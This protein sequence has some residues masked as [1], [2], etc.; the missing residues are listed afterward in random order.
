MLADALTRLASARPGG[1]EPA[2]RSPGAEVSTGETLAATED[3][4]D[5]LFAV[6]DRLPDE[7]RARVPLKR[8]WVLDEETG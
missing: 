3:V 2:A 7:T 4:L 6:Y 1:S 8:I 5:H